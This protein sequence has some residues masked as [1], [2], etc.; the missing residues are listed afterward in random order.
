MVV[1]DSRVP[2][3]YV[4]LFDQGFLGVYWQVPAQMPASAF[5]IESSPALGAD[6]EWTAEAIDLITA[7]KVGWL[8]VSPDERARFYRLRASP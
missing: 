6:A 8:F 7:E 5:V 2:P 3:L 4:Y 1:R